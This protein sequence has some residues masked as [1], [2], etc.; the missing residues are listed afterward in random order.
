MDY[1]KPDISLR[2]IISSP[3]SLSHNL[4]NHLHKIFSLSL[5]TS[6]SHIYNSR[7]FLKKLTNL[8]LPD[9]AVLVSLDVVSLFT[10][11]PVDLVLEILEEKWS[12][13]Q[14]HTRLPTNPHSSTS[15]INIINKH[16]VHPWDPHFLQ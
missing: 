5:P 11:V 2:I 14:E 16:L 12:Y 8:H 10:N 3:G 7:D 6:V 1:H 15:T 13:F 9:D 4:A